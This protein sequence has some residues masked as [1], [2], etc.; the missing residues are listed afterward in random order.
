VILINN[1]FNIWDQLSPNINRRFYPLEYKEDMVT[2]WLHH[3][4]F[5]VQTVQQY[6]DQFNKLNM[7]VIDLDETL[8][9]KF[10]GR[11]IPPLRKEM[12]LLN[13]TSLDQ[14]FKFAMK[15]DAKIKKGTSS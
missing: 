8:Q 5:S 11:S 12:E 6:I 2:Q 15:I 7:E 1:P 10:I 9:L 14:A 4:Q 3:K 13:I